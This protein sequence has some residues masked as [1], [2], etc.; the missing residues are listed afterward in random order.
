MLR[1]KTCCI[2][3][4][5]EARLAVQYGADALGLV[6][7][8]PSGPGTLTDAEIAAIVPHVPPP[9][10]TF[11]LTSETRAADIIKHHSRVH[12]NTIQ[13]VDALADD[14][15]PA[16]RA[17]L[18]S[19]KIV[20]V[21][22]VTGAEA[23]DEALR[24]APLVDALLLDSGNPNLSVKQLGGTGRTHDWQLSRRIVDQS[25][26]PVFLAGGL[27]AENVQRAIA[28]VQPHGVDLCSG[29]RANG[30]LDE[31]KLAG[32]FQAVGR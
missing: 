22:H 28:E 26:T 5:Q 14:A 9:V 6:G 29:I 23:V 24:I 11:L 1:V 21:V 7:P 20:Q 13:L 27:N 8:M 25:D 10:A 3:N 12:T 15:Y 31:R 30:R 4:I 2:G 19:V 17:A 32:F 16:L 18:P